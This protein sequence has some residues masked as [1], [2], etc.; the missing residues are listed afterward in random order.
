VHKTTR[1]WESL[2]RRPAADTTPVYSVLVVD[3]VEAIRSTLAARLRRAGYR[4]LV[5]ATASEALYLASNLRG[6]LHLLLTDV[7][8]PGS[9]G[10]DLSRELRADRPGL[11]VIYMSGVADNAVVRGGPLSEAERMLQKPST[12]DVLL[13]AMASLL[14]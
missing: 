6:H 13:E 9:S 1:E 11:R 3:D 5:A 7:V 2:A 4:V 8:M 14:H 12:G 10:L